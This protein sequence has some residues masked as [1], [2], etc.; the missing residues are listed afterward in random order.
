MANGLT[1]EI[2]HRSFS[3]RRDIPQTQ[4]AP[5]VAEFIHAR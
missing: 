4:S 5:R 3:P 1:G 2:D